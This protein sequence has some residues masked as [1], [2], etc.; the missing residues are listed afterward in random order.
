MLQ[1]KKVKIAL[2]I[3]IY[4]LKQKLTNEFFCRLVFFYFCEIR[5]CLV[6]V[7]LLNTLLLVLVQL[8]C[9]FNFSACFFFFFG[10]FEEKKRK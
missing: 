5:R 1:K 7:L 6:E 9:I 3:Y 4:I 2:S 8:P 10:A